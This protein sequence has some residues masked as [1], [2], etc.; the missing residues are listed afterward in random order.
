MEY[1]TYLYENKQ[2]S[3]IPQRVMNQSRTRLNKN[4]CYLATQTLVKKF[5]K[6]MRVRH[7]CAQDEICFHLV[8]QNLKHIFY[9]F[10][11]ICWN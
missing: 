5:L 4:I 2:T 1:N 10:I 11:K 8:K 6:D 9:R 3:D 7:V